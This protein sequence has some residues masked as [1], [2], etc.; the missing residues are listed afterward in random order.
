MSLGAM[1]W[2]MCSWLVAVWV[3]ARVA[4]WMSGGPRRTDGVMHGMAVWSFS[5]AVILLFLT[6]AVGIL[7][8][9]GGGAGGT[10]GGI[11]YNS[12][13]GAG[14]QQQALAPSHG[15]NTGGSAMGGVGGNAGTSGGGGG[16]VTNQPNW[17]K[18]L[19]TF[20]ALILGLGVACAGGATGASALYEEDRTTLPAA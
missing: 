8:G 10:G 2:L 7:G 3:G 11:S 18:A 13:A 9:G 12:G 1:I 16:N 19:W 20:V 4:G 5:A 17:G 6:G 15:G 14:Q